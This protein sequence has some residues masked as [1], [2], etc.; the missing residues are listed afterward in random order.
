LRLKHDRRV[1]SALFHG[2]DL[3]CTRLDRI[4]ELCGNVDFDWS[5]VDGTVHTTVTDQ[6]SEF[7]KQSV[8]ESAQCHERDRVINETRQLV[9]VAERRPCE[10]QAGQERL[11]DDV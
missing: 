7:R 1:A 5:F 8:Q 9:Y 3:S 2:L 4:R 10:L 11:L 6:V